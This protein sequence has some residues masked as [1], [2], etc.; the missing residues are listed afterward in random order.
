MQKEGRPQIISGSK[1]GDLLWWDPRFPGEPTRRVQAHK[2]RADD[3]MTAFE[4]HDYAPIL[5]TASP[6][7]CIKV[8]CRAGRREREAFPGL[9]LCHGFSLYPDCRPTCLQMF[10]LEGDPIHQYKHYNSFLG[11]TKHCCRK[12]PIACDCQLGRSQP[13]FSRLLATSSRGHRPHRRALVPPLQAPAGSKQ[14]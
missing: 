1:R 10:S 7:S 13:H 9:S 5:A 8:R 14:L 12:L 3:S 4:V 6:N 11:G 2:L